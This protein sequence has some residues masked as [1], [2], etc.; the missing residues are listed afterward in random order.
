[1][2]SEDGGAKM[3]QK[4]IFVKTTFAI[5]YLEVCSQ[6]FD[7]NCKPQKS[8]GFRQEVCLW[9]MELLRHVRANGPN[10]WSSQRSHFAVI[11]YWTVTQSIFREPPLGGHSIARSLNILDSDNLVFDLKGNLCMRLGSEWFK[12]I[13]ENC[14]QPVTRENIHNWWRTVLTTSSTVRIN[15]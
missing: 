7:V 15:I 11:H 3:S 9:G 8:G 5:D 13:S 10:S 6:N 2:C 14:T 12:V 1:M 4:D